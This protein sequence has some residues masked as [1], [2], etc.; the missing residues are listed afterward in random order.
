MKR[1]AL[2]ASTAITFG[3]LAFGSFSFAANEETAQQPTIEGVYAFDAATSEDIKGAINSVT[4]KMNFIVKGVARSRLTK[5]NPAY[6]RIAIAKEGNEIVVTLDTRKPIRMPADGSSIKWTREDGEKFNLTAAWQDTQL[7]QTYVAEDG[8][9]VN[10]FSLGTDGSTMT[11]AVT[12][13]SEQLP[14]P[15]QYKLGYKRVTTE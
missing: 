14:R 8:Q 6:Q 3:L 4:S 10:D 15:M 5:T 7:T 11:L 9:R 2:F 12:V 13:S 1:T